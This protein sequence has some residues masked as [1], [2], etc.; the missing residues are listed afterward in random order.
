M[1]YFRQNPFVRILIPLILGVFC[2]DVFRDELNSIVNYVLYFSLGSTL[3]L[4]LLHFKLKGFKVLFG[5]LVQCLFFALGLL[6]YH[7]N[8]PLNDEHHFSKIQ[9]AQQYVGVV[10][11]LSQKER[12]IEL[13]VNLENCI[14]GADSAFN[15]SGSTI[16]YYAL[17]GDSPQIGDRIQFSAKL[18][19]VKKNPN[20]NSFDYSR[21]LY[22][23]K[24][25]ELGYLKEGDWEILDKEQISKLEVW[26]ND[27]RSYCYKVLEKWING[28][29]R[30]AIANAML[31]GQ[32]DDLDKETRDAFINTGAIH[33]LAVSGLHVGILSMIVLWVLN[34]FSHESFVN[35][36]VKWIVYLFVIWMFA[37][38][39]GSGSAVLRASLMF[40]FYFSSVIFSKTTSSINNL[41]ASAFFIL[42][43]NPYQLFMIGFQF[44][45]L[46]LSSILLFMP[47]IQKHYQNQHKVLQY[48]LNLVVLSFVAQVLVA[49]LGI[50]YFNQFAIYFVLSGLVAV[51]S[52]FVILCTSISLIIFDFLFPVCNSYLIAPILNFSL[53]LLLQ[54]VHS[55]QD[56]PGAVI[57]NLF[58]DPIQIILLSAV[59]VS[60]LK[61]LF[62]SRDS[63]MVFCLSLSVL[64][65]YACYNVLASANQKVCFVYNVPKD[66]LIDIFVGD[67]CYTLKSESIS[68]EGIAY[69]AQR[70]RTVHDII[71]VQDLTYLDAKE[72]SSVFVNPP[73]YQV[74][75]KILYI[76]S[77]NEA[78]YSD[79]GFGIDY[80]IL[81]HAVTIDLEELLQNYLVEHVIIDASFSNYKK[82]KYIDVLEKLEID[83]SLTEEKVIAIYG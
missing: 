10:K 50:S 11:S 41:A 33:V 73:F 77:N 51:P 15:C 67:Q 76:V 43:N 48:A 58:F 3:L 61:L 57:K 12:R 19:K 36:L 69:T 71:K 20:P 4:L 66:S 45:F 25:H 52:A 5:C 53:Y 60:G 82:R 62:E 28:K 70:N 74:G 44:S 17:S 47:I 49:P 37:L 40:S 75:D 24:I 23:K 81:S 30:L 2:A 6:H 64:Q 65:V 21:Y 8:N 26:A 35:R 78:V 56:L 54:S 34:Y 63:F 1:V 83:Y 39:T 22:F 9:D 32:R 72:N 80:L 16:L 42:M 68:N 46:A 59:F 38:V 29:E 79:F 55:I 13:V 14:V 27:C 31:L 7:S 18:S